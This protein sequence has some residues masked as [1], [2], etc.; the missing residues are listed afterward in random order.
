[1]GHSFLYKGFSQTAQSQEGIK[2]LSFHLNLWTHLKGTNLW[3][4]DILVAL[5]NW[6]EWKVLALHHLSSSRVMSLRSQWFRRWKF[7]KGPTDGLIFGFLVQI[8]NFANWGK[9]SPFIQLR[10]FASP[11]LLRTG[12]TSGPGLCHDIWLKLN[13][14]GAKS[15]SFTLLLAS[16]INV[17]VDS[18]FVVCP[19]DTIWVFMPGYFNSNCLRWQSDKEPACT[20][21]TKRELKSESPFYSKSVKPVAISFTIAPCL[22]IINSCIQSVRNEAKRAKC[23]VQFKSN[24]LHAVTHV[25]TFC[26]FRFQFAFYSAESGQAT[27]FPASWW[28]D[29]ICRPWMII[30]AI[31]YSAPTDRVTSGVLKQPLT[32]VKTDD[33][34][35]DPSCQWLIPCE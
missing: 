33:G 16:D 34:H 14:R 21:D 29:R 26:L 18:L 22:V 9:R 25:V 30:C 6:F 19:N 35:C 17:H 27:S 10:S 15:V 8:F 32:I 23:P 31:I 2:F 3:M 11:K 20:K 28:K 7:K 24:P 5:V 12:L 1:M 13:Y 4:Q